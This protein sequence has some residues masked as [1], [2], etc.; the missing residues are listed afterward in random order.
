MSELDLALVQ[1]NVP[2]KFYEL[3]F[4]PFKIMRLKMLVV[5]HVPTNMHIDRPTDL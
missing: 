2:V 3:T 1:M 4:I 5:V